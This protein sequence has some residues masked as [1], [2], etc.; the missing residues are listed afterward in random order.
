MADIYTVQVYQADWLRLNKEAG[1]VDVSTKAGNKVFA[2]PW[3]MTRAHMDGDISDEEY[4]KKYY[5]LM[6]ESYRD[7]RKEWDKL[8][9]HDKIYL[10]CY[11]NTSKFCHR[12]LLADMLVKCG[13]TLIGEKKFRKYTSGLPHW[14]S[15]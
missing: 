15:Y 11:C 13:A 10:G 9:E 6:R 7:N 14:K 5:E 12:F 8:L 2:P 3:P 1:Y 4:E